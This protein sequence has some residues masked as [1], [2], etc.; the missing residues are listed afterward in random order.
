MAGVMSS[1]GWRKPRRPP[2]TVSSV[3]L[4]SHDGFAFFQTP[5]SSVS[6]AS[7]LAASSGFLLSTVSSEQAR[8]AAHGHWD[9][10]LRSWGDRMG[11]ISRRLGG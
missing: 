7:V 3:P 8:S 11:C 9:T 4:D 5:L 1:A 10:L 2:R 6:H